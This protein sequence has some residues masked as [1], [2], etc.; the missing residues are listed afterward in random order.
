M[1]CLQEKSSIYFNISFINR[2][3]SAVLYLLLLLI[4]SLS[5]QVP[6]QAHCLLERSTWYRISTDY[7]A[8]QEVNINHS[9]A[10]AH[11]GAHEVCNRQLPSGRVFSRKIR[12]TQEN[13]CENYEQSEV[14]L[15]CMEDTAD[16]RSGM[17]CCLRKMHAGEVTLTDN[18]TGYFS[19]VKVLHG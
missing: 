6:L 17:L 11:L 8:M 7:T 16:F 9:N 15:T 2:P 1:P 4:D 18:I 10:G 19:P 12:L 5:T 3:S 13:D 14:C